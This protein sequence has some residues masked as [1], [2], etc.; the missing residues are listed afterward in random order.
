MQE[1]MPEAIGQYGPGRGLHPSRPGHFAVISIQTGIPTFNPFAQAS[2]IFG[3]LV[4]KV[5]T[6]AGRA[7]LRAGT[8]F[9]TRHD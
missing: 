5:E 9:H 3:G 2:S 1:A 8:A 6:V 7:D 4:I